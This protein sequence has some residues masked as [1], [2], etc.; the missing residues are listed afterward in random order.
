MPIEYLKLDIAST[1]SV[2]WILRGKSKKSSSRQ[3]PA[4]NS[5]RTLIIPTSYASAVKETADDSRIGSSSQASSEL[6]H[7]TSSPNCIEPRLYPNAAVSPLVSKSHPV[8]VSR[9]SNE[10]ITRDSVSNEVTGRFALRSLTSNYSNHASTNNSE[11]SPINGSHSVTGG[12]TYNNINNR[13]NNEPV[14][15]F[16]LVTNNRFVAVEEEECVDNKGTMITDT[17]DSEE[18]NVILAESNSNNNNDNSDVVIVQDS[19]NEGIASYSDNSGIITTPHSA[20]ITVISGCAAA[21]AAAAPIADVSATS[22]PLQSSAGDSRAT[23][24]T[25]NSNRIETVPTI[26][27]NPASLVKKK[28]KNRRKR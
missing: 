1:D 22:E 13:L 10:S 23:L 3:L 25:D 7:S 4:A 18:D 6:R 14:T 12:S 15:G 26:D 17:S 9:I 8:T 2:P 21:V 28:N 24:A 20:D 11:P 27:K 19:N 16:D 5:G